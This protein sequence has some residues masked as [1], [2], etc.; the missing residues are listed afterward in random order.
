MLSPDD[1]IQDIG[2]SFYIEYQ[3]INVFRQRK[4]L[5]SGLATRSQRA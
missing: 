2:L 1:F 3:R 4:R 5:L